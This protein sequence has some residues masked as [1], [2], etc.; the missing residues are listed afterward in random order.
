[1]LQPKAKLNGVVLSLLGR[2]K[3]ALDATIGTLKSERESYL[4]S[5]EDSI[6]SIE[7]EIAEHRRIRALNRSYNSRDDWDF[8]K[9]TV[10]KQPAWLSTKVCW[11]SLNDNCF[12]V[13]SDSPMNDPLT[14]R[15]VPGQP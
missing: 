8:E 7:D 2:L 1:M 6:Q 9:S 10:T 3:E 5:R 4:S 12:F 14:K 15:L 11:F 13:L